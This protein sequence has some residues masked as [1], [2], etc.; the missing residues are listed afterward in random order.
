MMC[1]APSDS[2]RAP[3]TSSMSG[4]AEREREPKA[5]GVVSSVVENGPAHGAL[6]AGDLVLSMGGKGPF[7]TILE[8]DVED[9]VISSARMSWTWMHRGCHHDDYHGNNRISSLDILWS[10]SILFIFF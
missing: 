4:E 1:L 8:F 7:R 9:E 3:S 5:F 2:A 6:V 10:S